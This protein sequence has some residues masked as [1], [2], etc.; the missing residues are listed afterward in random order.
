MV[1]RRKAIPTSKVHEFIQTIKNF[2]K[3]ARRAGAPKKE[4]R[5]SVMRLVRIGIDSAYNSIEWEKK[6]GD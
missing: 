6:G 3:A 2:K 1:L 5:K 4:L